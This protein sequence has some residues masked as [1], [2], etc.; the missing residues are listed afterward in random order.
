MAVGL[1]VL[2]A[3]STGCALLLGDMVIDSET[4]SKRTAFVM[5]FNAAQATRFDAKLPLLDWCSEC[6]GFDRHWALSDKKCTD[7]IRR[8]EAGDSAA[9]RPPTILDN[10]QRKPH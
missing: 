10:R 1:L 9:L 5:A 3:S 4:R 2:L 6:Y 7:R 8:Y